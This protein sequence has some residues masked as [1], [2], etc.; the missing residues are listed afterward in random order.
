MID[1]ILV[2]LYW[3]MTIHAENFASHKHQAQAAESCLEMLG[4]RWNVCPTPKS[5]FMGSFLF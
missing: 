4:I 2:I 1:I 3:W 5:K